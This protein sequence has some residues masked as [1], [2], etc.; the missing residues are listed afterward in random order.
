MRVCV[1]GLLEPHSPWA[2]PLGTSGGGSKG[3]GLFAVPQLGAE[4]AVFFK[5]GDLGAPYYLCAHWGKPGGASEVPQEAQGTPPDN[6]VFSTQT[7]AVS[8]DETEGHRKLSLLNR[9]TGDT[10]VF[11][12]E[13]NSVRLE[14]TT[15]ITIKAVGA[16]SIEGL[17]ITIGGRIVRPT[18]DPI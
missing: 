7:F 2:F 14:G 13:E 11:D 3:Y 8:L 9:K 17:Q 16:V 1:P 15:A 6:Y 12:A 4:V 10:L 18:S 5:E